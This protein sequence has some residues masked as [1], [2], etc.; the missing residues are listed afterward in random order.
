[1]RAVGPVLRRAIAWRVRM[2]SGS[3][4]PEDRLALDAWLAHD[5]RHRSAWTQVDAVLG[6]PL[7]QLQA[8]EARRQGS[9]LASVRTLTQREPSRR[10]AAGGTLAL[11]L[12]A[13]GTAWLVDRQT[14]MATL[15][16]DRR[17]GTAHR[18][19]ERLAD[20]SELLLNA[21]SAVDLADG[22]PPARLALREGQVAL[23]TQ[24]TAWELRTPQGTPQGTLQVQ[25]A[26]CFVERAG[27]RSRFGLL[28]GAGR[29][30]LP[31]Q[32]P[33][34]LREGQACTVGPDGSVA[35]H[36]DAQARGAW[37]EGLVDARD[38]PLAEVVDA[39]RPWFA[40]VIRL[41]PEAAALRLSAVLPLDRPREAL[42]SLADTQP[43]RLSSLGPWLLRIDRA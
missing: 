8:A 38:A 3:A 17:T 15:L 27:P 37:T 43:I 1:M 24:G 11:A 22:A 13:A 21:R 33:L 39:L 18:R 9:R 40:G 4:T 25:S 31:D 7:A 23:R 28:A 35:L 14:P 32:R 29:L 19:N 6:A 10:R 30:L 2:D 26:H 34:W 36:A 42:R 20:G 12:A 5:P 16:A 41:A